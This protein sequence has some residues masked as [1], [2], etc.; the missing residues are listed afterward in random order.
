MG[1]NIGRERGMPRSIC[2]TSRNSILVGTIDGY[3]INFDIRYNII[4]SV[5][6]LYNDKET[7]PITNIYPCPLAIDQREQ[8]F[9]FTYPSKHYEFSYFNIHENSS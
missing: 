2:A 7:L 8:M 5:L 6:Q 9:A 4:S 3:I 1:C